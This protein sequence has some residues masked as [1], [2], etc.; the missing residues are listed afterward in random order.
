MSSNREQTA[1]DLIL[2]SIVDGV[3]TVDKNL[4]ITTF[5]KAAEDITG[6]TRASV[7]GASCSQ[8]FKTQYCA[9]G[10]P[11]KEA[12]RTGSPVINKPVSIVGSNGSEK[13]VFISAT[14]LRDAARVVVGGVATLRDM[15]SSRNVYDQLLK[16]HSFESIISVNERMQELF[17]KLPEVADSTAT[18]LLEGES[19]TGKEL[20]AR[21]IHNLSPRRSKPFVAVN[22]AALPDTLLESELFGYK[23]GAFTGAHKDKPGRFQLA[24]R[25]TI[26]LDEIGDVSCAMQIRLLRVLQER[27]Y[28]PLGDVKSVKADVRV[29][30]ATNKDIAAM[31][32][33]GEFRKDLYY[34]INVVRIEIPPLRKRIEDIPIL[35]NHFIAQFNE[36]QRKMVSGISDDALRC[37]MSHPFPGNVREL[38]N[39][40]EHAILLCNSGLIQNEHLPEWLAGAATGSLDAP[41]AAPALSRGDLQ[42]ATSSFKDVEATFL[43]DALRRNNWNRHA[44]ARE[45]GIHKAT[46]YRKINA[47]GLHPPK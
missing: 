12:L 2:D 31:V 11:M 25:G 20:F 37:L 5:N 22:C 8:V 42:P 43:M 45:L 26:F 14:P 40:I 18:I 44:T 32:E 13:T 9:R 17:R 6:M 28:E 27:V 33:T 29:V 15:T 46:L 30:V 21:A 7:V 35:V 23:A 10:C 19:G 38:E 3:F 36:R 41:T 47:L 1:G 16:H 24:E 4:T 34:R 39:I